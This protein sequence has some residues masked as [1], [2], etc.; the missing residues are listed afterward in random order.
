[1]HDINISYANL[2]TSHGKITAVVVI[3]LLFAF[4]TAD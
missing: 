1:M 4:L 3:L 2:H